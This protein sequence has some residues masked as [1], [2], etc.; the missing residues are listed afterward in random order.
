MMF[1]KYIPMCFLLS[2]F[3]WIFLIP[4]KIQLVFWDE[5]MR[6][7]FPILINKQRTS[8]PCEQRHMGTSLV[9]SAVRTAASC[10]LTTQPGLEML[11]S[12]LG[13]GASQVAR[14]VKNPPGQCRRGKRH[15]FPPWVGKSPWSRK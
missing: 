4:P 9:L 14:V 13:R 11:S 10:I 6:V 3:V 1:G 5:V 2:T 8:S 7:S 15:S 12:T